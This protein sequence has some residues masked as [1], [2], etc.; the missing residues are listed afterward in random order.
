[1][2][3]W[4]ILTCCPALIGLLLAPWGRAQT[5]ARSTVVQGFVV[6]DRAMTIS[7][8]VITATR[9][10]AKTPDS[11][12]VPVN[13]TGFYRFER[14]P[15]G[16]YRLC[17]QSLDAVFVDPCTWGGARTITLNAG[18]RLPHV[19]VFVQRARLLRI[20]VA[21]AGAYIDRAAA[22]S[23]AD[24]VVGV[25]A[26]ANPRELVSARHA[27]T[28]ADGR[29]YRLAVP[30]GV[31]MTLEVKSRRLRLHDSLGREAATAQEKFRV[32][33]DDSGPVEKRFSVAGLAAGGVL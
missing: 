10:D 24:L 28:V 13:G 12:T 17:A 32:P 27:A 23:K 7:G 26:D 6:A 21:G 2:F 4:R 1:M 15:P 16:S 11:F 14:L 18:D 25:R 33:D 19:L 9:L 3:Y 8:S 29:E 20:Y 5:P 22:A 31:P 30:V